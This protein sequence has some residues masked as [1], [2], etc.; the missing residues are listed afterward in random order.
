[1]NEKVKILGIVSVYLSGGDELFS[2][3]SLFGVM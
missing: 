3:Q 2:L 1:M